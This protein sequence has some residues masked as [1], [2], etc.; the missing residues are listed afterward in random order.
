VGK[1]IYKISSTRV[2]S[3]YGYDSNMVANK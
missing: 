3:Q 2:L 1:S